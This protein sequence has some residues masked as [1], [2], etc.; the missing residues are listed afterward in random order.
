[1]G[2]T[3]SSILRRRIRQLPTPLH[4]TREE[5]SRCPSGHLRPPTINSSSNP[6][7]FRNSNSSNPVKSLNSSSSNRVEFRSNSNSNCSSSNRVEFR[8]NSNC[9]SSS[10]NQVHKCCSSRR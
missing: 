1:M 10:S 2:G 5:P 7:G 8:S 9:S 3:S 6:V 4:C